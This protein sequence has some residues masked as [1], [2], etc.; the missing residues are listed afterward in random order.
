MIFSLIFCLLTLVQP[1][2]EIPFS[3]LVYDIDP[4]EK[5]FHTD[6]WLYGSIY[7]FEEKETL[8]SHQAFEKFNAG[9]F[10][11]LKNS[12][13][14]NKGFTKSHWWIGFKLENKGNEKRN[15]IFTTYNP[16]IKLANLFIFDEIGELLEVKK[17]GYS[18]DQNEKDV[19]MR[20]EEFNFLI[21][22]KS[23][24]ILLVKLDF[25]LGQSH[26]AHYL[27]DFDIWMRDMSWRGFL[28][29]I[30]LGR[31]YAVVVILLLIFIYF[32]K[33]MYLFFAGYLASGFMLLLQ[34]DKWI[35]EYISF[36]IEL[37]L[38]PIILPFFGLSVSIFAW[39]FIWEFLNI[40][41]IRSKLI[42]STNGF[43]LGQFTVLLLIFITQ[44]FQISE[45]LKFIVYKSALYLSLINLFLIFLICISQIKHKKGEAIFALISNSIL[46][47]SLGIYLLS[48]LG[49]IT[50]H[51]FELILLGYG[52][53]ANVLINIIGMVHQYY[54]D[55]K[56]KERLILEQTN[57]EKEIV[58][59][60]IE[61]Q[62]KERQ[63][64]AKDLHDDLGSNLAMIKLR[65][66]LLMENQTKPN[67]NNQ[68]FE[69]IHQL[70]DGACKDLRYIS[71]ELMPADLSTKVMR[72]MVEELVEKLSVQKR[73]AIRAKVEEI[74]I[75]S[76]DT[77]VNLFR[78]IK[79][80]MNNILK[81]AQ[82]TE[83][84]IHLFK[85]P[86]SETITLEIS[87]NGKGMPKEVMEGKSKGMGLKNLEKRVEY[88]N[89]KL[90]IQSSGLG[91][92]IRVDIPLESNQLA[93][94]E[95]NTDR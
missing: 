94:E 32:Q 61:A 87:D 63:R 36:K 31:F 52:I 44:L 27:V 74:P 11:R 46:I 75:L 59:L 25:G 1:G 45:I 65:M 81:H 13:V 64:I 80:L 14:L 82:A 48:M 43:I 84:G 23:T 3:H 77:K 91:T 68:N 24:Q 83:A 26:T 51:P 33:K 76:I 67:G 72:T 54:H 2:M 49:Y 15:F 12:A 62:D 53:T 89:G 9:E 69:E 30:I 8:D 57:T 79:E 17:T 19:N 40:G 22:G 60:T 29:G 20:T 39:L 38:S 95:N 5:W 16:S 92:L 10:T 37:F 90:H 4:N 50:I 66:E 18:L 21:P 70:L 6:S 88:L 41:R 86:D 47:M 56:E 55:Q 28:Y 7:Y 78:I 34:S 71:H 35:G 73:V 93:Y 42:K 85:L 58:R